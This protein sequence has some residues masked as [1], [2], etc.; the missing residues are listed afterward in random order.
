MHFREAKQAAD[1]QDTA[2]SSLFLSTDTAERL[3]APTQP[4]HAAMHPITHV[5]TQSPK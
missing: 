5:Q 2:G 4:L 1:T 3:T